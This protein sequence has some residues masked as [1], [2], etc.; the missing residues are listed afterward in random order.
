MFLPFQ[1]IVNFFK[2]PSG[3]KCPECA[4]VIIDDA[5]PNLDLPAQDH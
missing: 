3:P 2:E 5:C 1:A 4:S